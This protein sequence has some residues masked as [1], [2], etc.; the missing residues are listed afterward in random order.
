VSHVVRSL[1]APR[2]LLWFVFAGALAFLVDVGVLHLLSTGWNVNLF[3]ARACS[4]TCAATTAWM[5]NRAFTFSANRKPPRGLLAEWTAY[6]AAS[7]GGGCVN[8]AVFALGVRWSPLLY[9]TPSLA[10]LIGTLAGMTFNF[11]MYAKYVFRV[12][13]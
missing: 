5:L 12:Y 2:T 4:F 13:G 10:V 1:A 3:L 9:E 6:L 11:V 7:L 8:Y